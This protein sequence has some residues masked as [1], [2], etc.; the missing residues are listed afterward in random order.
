[1]S[2]LQILAK[3]PGL[4]QQANEFGRVLG[5]RNVGLDIY[6]RSFCT[7][8]STQTLVSM[9]SSCLPLLKAC[10]DMLDT[11]C[12]CFFRVKM[13]LFVQR[14]CGLSF[15]FK[16]KWPLLETRDKSLLIHAS[17]CILLIQATFRDQTP[18]ARKEGKANFANQ[19]SFSKP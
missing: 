14:G 5:W 7:D 1:M 12:V 16:K 11:L 15:F 19:S 8:S 10:L 9:W 3:M 18:W 13:L 6:F 2:P 4:T 17:L